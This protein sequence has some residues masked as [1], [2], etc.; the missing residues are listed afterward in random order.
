[1][2]VEK[3]KLLSITGKEENI[4]KFISDYLLDSGIQTENAVKIFEKG[5][6]LTNF[7]YDSTAKDLLKDC[8]ELLDKYKIKYNPNIESDNI[9]KSLEV[10]KKELNIIK[11]NIES[12]E[13]KTNNYKKELQGYEKELELL[14]HTRNLNINLSELYNLEYIK[15]R[16]GRMPKENFRK[17]ENSLKNLNA[18]LLNVEDEGEKNVWVICLATKDQ[19]AKVDSYLNVYK[20]E[21]VWIPNDMIGNPNELWNEC[22][23]KIHELKFNIENTENELT[24]IVDRDTEELIE[25]Y[26]EI[27]LYI[28]INNVKKFMAYDKN[29]LFYI[30]G[31]I[32]AKELTRI[33]P[34]LSKEKDIKYDIKN[35]DEVARYTS[36]KIEK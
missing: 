35:H 19:S 29:G 18:I 10:V 11:S 30:I 20:F 21:R 28:K 12:L 31:W 1:M 2:A 23:S 16:Y 6:K 27:N 25:L 36:N 26:A 17:L 15:F 9:N 14:M 33:L 22:E 24:R 13:L 7:Q 5:W 8:K 32:P 4:D 34:K 3:M